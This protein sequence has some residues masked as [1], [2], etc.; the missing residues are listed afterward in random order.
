MGLKLVNEGGIDVEKG[1]RG[2][3]MERW[4][5]LRGISGIV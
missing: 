2:E 1:S 3:Y 5:K 4:L